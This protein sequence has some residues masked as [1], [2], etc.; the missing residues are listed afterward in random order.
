MAAIDH[1]PRTAGTVA[2]AGLPVSIAAFA[3]VH[4]PMVAGLA[5][6]LMFAASAIC[7]GLL[8][9]ALDLISRCVVAVVM[10]VCLVVITAEAMLAFS[11]W[12]AGDGLGVAT[13][14][15]SFFSVIAYVR[16]DAITAG[17]LR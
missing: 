7:V 8:L 15:W 3:G 12:S 14:L 2:V 5:Y 10:V 17:R 13:A 9:P 6:L 11:L 4:S 1:R 16:L